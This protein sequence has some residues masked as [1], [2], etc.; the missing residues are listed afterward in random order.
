MHAARPTA[1]HETI[2]RIGDRHVP[3]GLVCAKRWP[4]EVGI[5]IGKSIIVTKT[6]ALKQ[7]MSAI[8]SHRCD[9]VVHNAK[10][11]TAHETTTAITGARELVA[12]RA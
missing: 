3:S 12:K 10:T 7:V 4:R 5:K 11:P 8:V 9:R 1:N 2:R 6:S